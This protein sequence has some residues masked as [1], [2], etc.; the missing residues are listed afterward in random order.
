MAAE[1]G[2]D[3][4][5]E[6]LLTHAGFIGVDAVDVTAAYRETQLAWMDRWSDRKDDLRRL[7]GD[8][9]YHERQEE[10]RLTLAAIDE[11]LLRRMLY[12]ARLPA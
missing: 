5:H 10:R 8:D 7:L 12:T 11:G 2:V 1:V 3:G 9:L 4:D 6:A